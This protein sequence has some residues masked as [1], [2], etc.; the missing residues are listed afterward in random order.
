MD[1]FPSRRFAIAPRLFRFRL[2]S[3][4]CRLSYTRHVIPSPFLFSF[5][6]KVGEARNTDCSSVRKGR[7]ARAR[8]DPR[9]TYV[10]YCAKFLAKLF[11]SVSPTMSH[12]R[13]R[14]RLI[15]RVVRRLFLQQGA[16]YCHLMPTVYVEIYLQ[17]RLS[18]ETL[19][20]TGWGRS[21]N[22]KR[23]VYYSLDIA[24]TRIL[25]LSLWWRRHHR[26]F[27]VLKWRLK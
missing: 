16:R 12:H 8:N 13:A 27:T 19:Q 10:K 14:N 24:W 1:F 23:K 7:V 3:P 11:A 26:I 2:R 17:C 6:S 15:S 4:N 9:S 5:C 21:K 18:C 20:I 25:K 22:Q